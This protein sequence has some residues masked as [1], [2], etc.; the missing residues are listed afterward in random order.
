MSTDLLARVAER[1][2]G[3]LQIVAVD[4][5]VKRAVSAENRES[6]ILELHQSDRL[7]RLPSASS[8]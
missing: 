7:I 2:L 6:L 1:Y 3:R 5:E 8:E 4:N